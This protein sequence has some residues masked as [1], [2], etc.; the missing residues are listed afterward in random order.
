MISLTHPL[1]V[2]DTETSLKSQVSMSGTVQ[3][4]GIGIGIGT[5]AEMLYKGQIIIPTLTLESFKISAF[6]S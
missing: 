2:V 1:Y 3:C 6:Y 4:I 5:G